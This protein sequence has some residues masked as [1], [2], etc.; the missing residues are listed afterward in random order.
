MSAIDK[1]KQFASALELSD[2]VKPDIIERLDAIESNQRQIMAAI[3][4]LQQIQTNVNTT[5]RTLSAELGHVGRIR[6]Q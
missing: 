3:D 6:R 1:V 4:Q 5:L 2:K